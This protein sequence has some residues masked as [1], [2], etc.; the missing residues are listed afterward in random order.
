MSEVVWETKLESEVEER[1][2]SFSNVCV[3]PFFSGEMIV[4]FH[5]MMNA[6]SILFSYEVFDNYNEYN[7]TSLESC[8]AL[9]E[10]SR[11]V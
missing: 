10:H 8:E 7:Y 1:I 6:Y 11:D 4:D 5:K 9:R 2:H 3:D